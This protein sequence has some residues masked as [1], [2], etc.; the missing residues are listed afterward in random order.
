MYIRKLLH[1]KKHHFMDNN[2]DNNQDNHKRRS[3]ILHKIPKNSIVPHNYCSIQ[4]C[5]TPSIFACEICKN[6]MCLKHKFGNK[7]YT[8][9]TYCYWNPNYYDIIQGNIMHY[10]DKNKRNKYFQKFLNCLSFE[11]IYK[12]RP[13]PS[14]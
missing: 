11:W 13:E 9:C 10:D 6:C 2:Q 12:I 14:Y 7:D 4:N 5:P 1:I 3:G 8:V